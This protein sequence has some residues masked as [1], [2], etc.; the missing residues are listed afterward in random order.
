L[1]STLAQVPPRYRLFSTVLSVASVSCA[2]ST[3]HAVG[4]AADL[5]PLPG[6]AT[7][8]PAACEKPWTLGVIGGDGRV[9][10]TCSNDVQRLPL[11]E[12][13]PLARALAP[14]LDP[15]RDRVCACA[16]KLRAP[17]FIDLVFTA[18]PEEGHLTVRANADEDADSEMDTAFAGCVGTITASYTPIRSGA[19]PG[20][21][22][23][24]I[25][26]VRLELEP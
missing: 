24:A 14:G 5:P 2:G 25:Y 8:V 23:T 17:P 12:S 7:G 4:P 9:V 26:P 13:G 19:C 22:A 3:P 20:G 18:K 16:T 15:A 1:G 21:P 6:P 10:V 11:D